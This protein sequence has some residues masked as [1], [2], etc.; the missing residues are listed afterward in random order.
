MSIGNQPTVTVGNHTIGAGHPVFVVAE[1]GATHDGNIERA[2]KLVELAAACGAN[3]VKLQ[4]VSPDHSYVKGTLSYEIFTQLRLSEPD[5]QRLKR[6]ADAAGVILFTTPG[7]FPSLEL[8]MRL[9]FPLMKVSSGL[10]TNLPLVRA[11]AKTGLPM[12]VSSGMAH[13]DEI[14]RTVRIAR[15][16]GARQIAAFH[17][18]SV[19]PAADRLLNL[20]AIATMRAALDLP[21]G[22]SD[23]TADA[24]ACAVA[25]GMGAAMIEKHLAV[26]KELAGPEA[27]TACDPDEFARMVAFVRRASEMVG[28][29][30]KA[31]NAEEEEGRR[32]FRRSIITRRAIRKGERIS[33]DDIG[34]MR[35]TL[36]TIGLPP[37]FYDDVIGKVALRDIADNE[38]LRLGMLGN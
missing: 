11:V 6:A 21:V 29:G 27:G 2:L 15:E 30:R 16:A 9:G 1:I 18:T 5:L 34:L 4:T 19:Y 31:P 36:E 13:L 33:G 38:P 3:A 22:Y 32:L 12:F 17:C 7:D 35:G 10:M 28:H 26:S 8:A 14:G 20:S 23:H 37:E 24:L 25:V